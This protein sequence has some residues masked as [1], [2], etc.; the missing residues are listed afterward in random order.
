MK[1]ILFDG[2]RFAYDLRGKGPVSVIFETGFG[3]EASEW[4]AVADKIAERASVF[5]Y[6]RPGRGESDPPSAPRDTIKIHHELNALLEAA[7]VN[8]PFVLVGHSFG[9]VLMRLFAD[10][11]R[12][13]VRGLVL[14][15]SMHSR[16][17]EA[18]GPAFPEPTAQEAAELTHMR[19]FWQHGWMQADSTPELVD[20][21]QSLK[22]DAKPM[23]FGAV[24][25]HVITSASFRNLP[26]LP[27]LSAK[28]QLQR[29]WDRLQKDFIT[30]STEASQTYLSES[31]HF[32][33]RDAPQAIT[34]AINPM[35]P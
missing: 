25:V 31:G 22:M 27:D 32:V 28:E 29:I 17:F 20:L 15:E 5:L 1:H 18:L 26:F 14:V 9:G 35:L 19:Q 6:D 4:E 12:D 3:A 11:R 2:R 13:D 34:E 30:L 7:S 8:P 16:Q 24:P 23:T 21:P 33:Q 10:H